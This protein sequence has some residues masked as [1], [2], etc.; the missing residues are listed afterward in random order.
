ME[1]KKLASYRKRTKKSFEYLWIIDK[2]NCVLR[3]V[4]EVFRRF[5]KMNP[6]QQDKKAI[7]RCL[8][9]KQA[10]L[11]SIFDFNQ[12]GLGS[13]EVLEN[14]KKEKLQDHA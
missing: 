3:G 9:W 14:I 8:H 2:N 12:L 4:H 1:R 7:T 6:A 5:L 13:L 11:N 10:K